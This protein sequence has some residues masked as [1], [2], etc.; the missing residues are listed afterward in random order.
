[1]FEIQFH[2]SATFVQLMK[3]AGIA[4]GGEYLR[5]FL[6]G[7]GCEKILAWLSGASKIFWTC[8][9]GGGANFFFDFWKNPP[10]PLV[11]T[12]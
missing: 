12:L 6:R 9:V 8:R 7:G 1:M 10:P 2:I 11:D 4:R 3:K 5:F